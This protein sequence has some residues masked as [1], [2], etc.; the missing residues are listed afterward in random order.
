MILKHKIHINIYIHK[1]IYT[2]HYDSPE[3]PHYASPPLLFSV[4]SSS[5]IT[6]SPSLHRQIHVVPIHA[7][8]VKNKDEYFMNHLWINYHI[9]KLKHIKRWLDRNKRGERV[10]GTSWDTRWRSREKGRV[11]FA[12]TNED[13]YRHTVFFF[14][15]CS[16]THVLL[17]GS[18]LLLLRSINKTKHIN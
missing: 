4:S 12:L 15:V 17:E 11:R 9:Y 13:F 8:R 16:V 10:F 6:T 1:Y 18:S 7:E 2:P 14:T 3:A 5:H